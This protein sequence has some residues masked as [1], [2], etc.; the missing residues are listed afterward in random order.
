MWEMDKNWD[1][2]RDSGKGLYR[3]NEESYYEIEE[4]FGIDFNKD[5]IIGLK[6]QKLESKSYSIW[7]LKASESIKFF[8]ILFAF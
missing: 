8:N 5:K 7:D 1:F 4:I 2:V 6:T 3:T